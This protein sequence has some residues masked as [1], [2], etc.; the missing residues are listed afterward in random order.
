[1]E[2]ADK[3][4]G[5]IKEKVKASGMKGCILGLSGG[6]DSAVAALLCKKAFSNNTLALILPCH[7]L[8]EDVE[9]AQAF[10]KKFSIDTKLIN[11][12]PVLETFYITLEGKTYR[13]QKDLCIANLKPRL[14]MA[15]LYYFANKMNYLVIGTGNKSELTMGYFT[16]YGDG[17]VDLLPL[18]DLTKT[19]VRKLA[20]EL[21]IPQEIIEKAPSAGLWHGQTDEGEMGIAYAELDNIIS[22]DISG[23]AKDKIELVN[24]RKMNSEHKRQLPEIFQLAKA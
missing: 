15:A 13:D 1:M 6:V 16:K 20:Q 24:K 5:W 10:A 7:S 23:I 3:I 8:S 12:T 9:H 18:G 4:S 14:R 2:L 17:G 21:S 11:L 22:G 19:E